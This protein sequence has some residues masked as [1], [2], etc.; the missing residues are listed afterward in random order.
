MIGP[1]Q[2]LVVGFDD[3]DFKGQ[4][5]AQLDTLRNQ[6]VVRVIDILLVQKDDEGEVSTRQ[7]TD[8]SPDEAQDL[9]QAVSALIGLGEAIGGDAEGAA[10]MWS[11]EGDAGEAGLTEDDLID[12]LAEI[13]NGSAVAIAL[14]EHRWAIPL[15]EAIISAGGAPI[16]DTWVHPRD[17]VEIGLLAAE[18]AQETLA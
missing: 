7:I 17:L 5:L 6:D 4:V 10:R 11:G 2:L 12:V 13:P 3:P 18:E 14:L 1:V 15:R 8:L 16:I 9:G